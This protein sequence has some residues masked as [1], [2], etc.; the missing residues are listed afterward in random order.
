M[1]READGSIHIY[2]EPVCEAVCP[3]CGKRCFSIH[4]STRRIVRDAPLMTRERVYV[5]FEARRVQ[6]SCG[7]HKTERPPWV[8]QRS[9]LTNLMMITSNHC[10][11]SVCPSAMQPPTT[12]WA[13][14]RSRLVT[15]FSS[16]IYSRK[17]ISPVCNTW[18]LTNSPSLRDIGTQRSSWIWT[19]GASCG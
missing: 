8:S 19:Q 18:P 5:Y 12:A 17:L 4:E 3:A 13:G 14:T 7:C 11:G 10:S 1:K 9:R 15:R 6:C 16:S 2:L